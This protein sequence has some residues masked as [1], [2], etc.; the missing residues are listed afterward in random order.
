MQSQDEREIRAMLDSW[1]RALRDKDAS[2]VVAH[3]APDYVSY[4]L[5]P[6]LVSAAD[7]ESGY[8]KWFETWRGKLEIAVRDEKLCVGGECAFSRC[9]VNLRGTKRDGEKI[10]LWFRQTLGLRK[11]LGT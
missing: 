9:L 8:E 1:T 2:G 6:P 3:H 10:D 11:V 4:S 5:A 7:A